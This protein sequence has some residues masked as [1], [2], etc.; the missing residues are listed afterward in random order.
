MPEGTGILLVRLDGVGDAALCVPALE[1]LRRA[2][3]TATFGAV[4]SPANAALYS[5]R[6]ERIHVLAKDAP[7][8]S[9]REEL[10]A[11]HYAKALVA[12]EEV[13]G[14]EL[15]RMSGAPERAGFW[16]RFHKPF[17][18]LWQRAQLTHAIYRPAAGT[19]VS[20]HE[21]QTLY[22]LAHA[23]GAANPAP[24]EPEELRAWLRI[25]PS[26]EAASAAG[27]V[28]IQ[29]TPKWR[30]LGYTPSA[31]AAVLSETFAKLADARGVFI[32]AK[33]DE[34]LAVAS[35]EHVAPAVKPRVRLA[36][37][38]SLPRWLGV[39]DALDTLVTPDTGAAHV[40]GML[41]RRVVDI[42]DTQDYERLSSQWHPWAGS[43][44][45]HAK[46]P[47]DMRWDA[48]AYGRFLAS[49]VETLRAA[50]A[51]ASARLR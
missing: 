34:D 8:S 10:V 42:F 2:F 45:S 9:L 44:R 7:V 32:A 1:G 15:A 48:A 24:A 17:K 33:S 21:V 13:A 25:E 49:E 27:A 26:A 3:P 39:V 11:T 19:Q 43:W 31:I 14:Y 18:S 30:T 12:T 23:L 50:P 47:L 20:E 22:R 51:A 16:H 28:G 46:R 38:L 41:G 29:I 37:S 6:V 5:D 36:I 40:A 35:F 4:C